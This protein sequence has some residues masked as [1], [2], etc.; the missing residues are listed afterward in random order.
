MVPSEEAYLLLDV[1][2]FVHLFTEDLLST[3]YLPDSILGAKNTSANQMDR[4]LSS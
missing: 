3:Y 2:T 1:A 4:S